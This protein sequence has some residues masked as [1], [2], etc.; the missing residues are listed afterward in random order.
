MKRP[1]FS[2]MILPTLAVVGIVGSVIYIASSQ[3]DRSLATPPETP[4]RTPEAQ[5]Q[6]GSV[7]GTGVVEPSSETVD[8]AAHVSGVV[9]RVFVR[10]GD[11]VAA[12]QPLL[13]IDSRTARA[14]VSEAAA[15]AATA[16]QSI[17][18]AQTALNDAQNQ[19]ALYQSIDDA[20]AVSQ[21]EVITRRDAVANAR[22]ELAVATAQARQAEAQLVQAR[23]ELER[24]TVR[25]PA[26][27]EVLQVDTRAGEFAGTQGTAA[28]L[29]KLGATKPLH[30]R[31][32]I[33]ENQIERLDI[34]KAAVISPRGDARRQVTATFVRAEPL[35][36][37]KV[38]LTNSATERVDVRVLQLIFALPD[39]ERGFFVGQ[40]VDGFVPAK[41][42][43]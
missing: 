34:G 21:Q 4:A 43:P 39:G 22:A 10:P 19:Y 37:P 31:L 26:A 35:I 33:D 13:E 1:S 23:V 8:I 20:R 5:R 38:S 16:R 3:P 17:A 29:L 11:Q 27:M 12:G 42:K 41:A 25:A 2:R 40:Q 18:A 9:A 6:S 30:I 15:Q 28:V 24:H 36:V 7:V 32:D 14:A